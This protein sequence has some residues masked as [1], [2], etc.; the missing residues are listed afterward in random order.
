M[1]NQSY[2]DSFFYFHINEFAPLEFRDFLLIPPPPHIHTQNGVLGGGGSAILNL[3]YK[4]LIQVKQ[5]SATWVIY[6]IYLYI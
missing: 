4:P 2:A 6:T 3:H 5:G 1:F